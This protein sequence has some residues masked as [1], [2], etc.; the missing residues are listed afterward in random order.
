MPDWITPLVDAAILVPF[1]VFCV[2]LAGLR[3]FSK[4]S[5][6]DF[7][8]TVSFGSVL[9]GTV[10]NPGTPLWQGMLAMASLFLVQWTIGLARSR[11]AAVRT[12]T[13]NE[14]LLLM[15]NGQFLER[16]MKHA[17]ITRSEVMAKLREANALQ[18]GQVKAMVLET[19]G[20]ISVLHGDDLNETLLDNVAQGGAATGG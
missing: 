4:M 8:V 17:R 14:P 1:M 10:L 11:I 7:A 12:L 3:A 16:N 6:Y 9:A 13:D 15:R 18:F 19:T 5:S 20:D 2:R